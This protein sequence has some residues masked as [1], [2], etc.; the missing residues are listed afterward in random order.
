MLTSGANTE[1]IQKNASTLQGKGIFD[2]F[3]P[4]LLDSVHR[5]SSGIK[6]F[7]DLHIK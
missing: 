5:K 1:Q 4:D 2:H 7:T 3:I 6:I